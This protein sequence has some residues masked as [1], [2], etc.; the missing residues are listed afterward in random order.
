MKLL[1]EII[2]AAVI[3]VGIIIYIITAPTYK[4]KKLRLLTK[5][6][7]ARNKSLAFQDILSTYILKHDAQH[8]I[9]ESG[10]TYAELLRQLRKQHSDHLSDKKYRKFRNSFFLRGLNEKD[11]QKQEKRLQDIESKIAH[12]NKESSIYNDNNSNISLA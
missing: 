2:V 11:L 1:P 7:R 8:E 4:K 9:I 5:Y 6:R 3:L 10:I 12:L